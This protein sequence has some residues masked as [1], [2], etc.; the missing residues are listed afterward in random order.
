MKELDYLLKELISENP[1]HSHYQIPNDLSGKRKLFR[2][3]SNI[4]PPLPVSNLF[5]EMQEA[6]LNRQVR[7]KGIVEL[8]QIPHTKKH[9]KI[10][11][12][13][14]DITRLKVDA[15]VNA[16]NSQML[17]CFSPLH[18]CIDN[19]IHS[20]AGV[21]L[22]LECHELMKNQGVAESTGGAK[23]TKG[24]NLPAKYVIHTVGPIIN[25][26]CVT[27]E[28]EMLLASCYR[29]CLTVAE[30][31]KFESIAFCCIS[32]GEFRFP[33]Q[34]AAE[35]ALGTVLNF[36]EENQKSNISTVVFNVFKDLDYAIYRQLLQKGER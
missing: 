27:I 9:T 17:G 21:Q 24:Y 20:A 14:G 11:L 18:G 5:L 19:A 13:Q 10:K 36:F 22:R 23:I 31:N 28:D 16:A 8:V 1:Q 4:R 12:W 33:N 32:T 26:D 25:N 7:K 15:V 29:S 35:I 34:R 3:L 2:I 6:E 30:Q